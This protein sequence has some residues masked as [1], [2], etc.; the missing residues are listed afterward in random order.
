MTVLAPDEGRTEKPIPKP[1][2]F[3]PDWFSV[4]DPIRGLFDDVRVEQFTE[5]NELVVRAELP[6]I[7][8]DK[9]VDITADHGR[10]TLSFERQDETKTE[11]RGHVRSEFRYGSF[12]RSLTLPPG[13][14]EKDVKAT[15]VDGILTIRMP[16]TEPVAGTK[17]PV[18]RL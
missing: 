11:G 13:A 10:L 14:D 16:F 6:G 17:V 7:D 1:V 8:P 15:Y 5:N 4:F 12:R 18:T 2:V 3:W 9:N